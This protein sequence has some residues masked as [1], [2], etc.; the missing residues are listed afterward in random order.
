MGATT[1]EQKSLWAGV[2]VLL[3]LQGGS[4]YKLVCYFTNWSQD[5]QEPGKFTPENV[6]PFL[7]S[8]LIYSFASIENNKVIIKDKS[9]V[10]LY[11]TI[12]SLKTK[13]PKLKILLSIGG[14]LFG[15]KGFHPMV[16]SSTSRLEFVNSVIL[17]LRN[18]NFDG[19]DVSWI[20]PDQKENTHFT[21]LIHELAEAFQKDFTKSTK[22]RLL[23][24]AGVSAGRQMI[25]NSYQ[26]EK[27][28]KDLDFINL[29]S[30]DFHGSWEKPLITGHNSPLSKGW[31]DRG[32]SSYYNVEYAVGYWIH[33]GMPSEKVVMGIPTYGHSFT[34]ATAETTVG[35]PA[36]GPGAAGPITESSGFLAYYEICQFLKGAK[37]TRLQD[38][39]VPYAVKGNQWVGYDDVESMETKVRFLKNLNLG[40]AMIWSID[41]DDFTGKSCNQGPYP[42]VQAVKRSLGSL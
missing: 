21:L 28:A 24:T 13:N 40:G 34:L 9:E 1:M 22:E 5:R 31:Q 32:P 33:K 42:L 36:S 39:Q 37:I 23:L 16:D 19:L 41:M 29:L 20:Y 35:A 38:Q 6:D 30:F 15:S 8:H 10:M 14:Y 26:V 3:L 18:H 17:F 25:D 12:N 11:Q 27:L 2:V 4:A 7:C